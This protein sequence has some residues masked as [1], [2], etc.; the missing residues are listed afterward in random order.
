MTRLRPLLA[1]ACTP[2]IRLPVLVL[3]LLGALLI[4]PALATDFVPT[5]Y[6]DPSPDGCLADDC[7]LR[8]AIIAANADTSTPHS[9]RLSAGT[10]SLTIPGDDGQALVGDL[11][12]LKAMTV[13]GVGATMTT[14]DATAIERAFH[15]YSGSWVSQLTIVGGVPPAGEAA[16]IMVTL[17]EV[18]VEGCELRGAP[19]G[20]SPTGIRATTGG[21][22]YTIRN[23]TVRGFSAEGIRSGGA[24]NMILENVTFSTNEIDLRISSS[25][26]GICTHC[27]FDGASDPSPEVLMEG[28]S[29]QIRN[30]VVGGHCTQSVPLLSGGGNLESPGDTCGFSQS[31][32]DA[33]VAN[34]LLSGLGDFGGPTPT[35]YPLAGSLAIDAA[36][37]SNCLASDQRGV[38]RPQGIGGLCDRGA[39][40]VA[41]FLPL[42][43]IFNDGFEQGNEGAW[44]SVTP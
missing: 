37:A 3:P 4:G 5:R 28:F 29:F 24:G 25:G 17:G 44:S 39:V 42:T 14:V 9:I 34:P 10:Y 15:V 16:A 19:A 43:P 11:D 35:H 18:T 7:S 21:E 32:D 8:E 33:S 26:S 20:M 1:L 27:T 22:D 38:G 23:S 31:D 12:L 41:G 40:E 2:S 6:D 30:S 13:I 36:R